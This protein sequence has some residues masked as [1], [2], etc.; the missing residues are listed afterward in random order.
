[1]KKELRDKWVEALRSGDYEQGMDALCSPSEDSDG[2]KYCCLGVLFE[3]E[4]GEDAWIDPGPGFSLEVKQPVAEE[5][6]ACSFY[7][8]PLARDAASELAK[9]NDNGASFKA[10]ADWIEEKVKVTK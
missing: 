1:M 3:V 2:F 7:Q 5:Y 10:I 6:S 8:G 4:N 9:M